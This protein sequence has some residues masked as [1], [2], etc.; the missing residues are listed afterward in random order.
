MTNQDAFLASV[1][2]RQAIKNINLYNTLRLSLHQATPIRMDMHGGYP[3]I[4]HSYPLRILSYAI[5]ILSHSI[6]FTI[7]LS[8]TGK[9]I[10]VWADLQWYKARECAISTVD[11]P[12]RITDD[13]SNIMSQR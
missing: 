9:A 4:C 5:W 12:A 10:P 7:Q 8:N 6:E 1:T 3:P 2:F 11:F 13:T